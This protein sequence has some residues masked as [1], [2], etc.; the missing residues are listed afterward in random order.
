MKL[1]VFQWNVDIFQLTS[2]FFSERQYF[3]VNNASKTYPWRFSVPAL[4]GF[5]RAFTHSIGIASHTITNRTKLRWHLFKFIIHLQISLQIRTFLAIFCRA[6]PLLTRELSTSLLGTLRRRQARP[7]K[8]SAVASSALS[9]LPS[10]ENNEQMYGYGLLG[11]RLC[12]NNDSTL[13][14]EDRAD[15]RSIA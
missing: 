7:Q 4:W 6:W 1:S 9:H 15:A 5:L 12:M 13:A 10:A 11:W 8:P 14:Q 3:S 2:V